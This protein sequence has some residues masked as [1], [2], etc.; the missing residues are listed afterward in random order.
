[1]DIAF[2]AISSVAAAVATS[3]TYAHTTTGSDPILF[4]MGRDKVAAA[5]V[6]TGITYNSVSL[7]NVNGVQIPSSR[8]MWIY[9]MVAPATGAHNVVV[10]ASESVSLRSY[11]ATYSGAKQSSQPDGNNTTTG[12]NPNLTISNTITTTA[13]NCWMIMYLN[14]DQGAITYSTSTGDTIRLNNDGGGMCFM[15]TGGPITPAGSNTMT[16]TGTNGSRGGLAV[17]FS[18]VVA[19]TGNFLSLLIP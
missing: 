8:F 11:A 6:V 4:A 12:T 10:S 3:L 16:L 17:S 2:D 15:D 13:D 19:S 5:S 7:T 9:Y 18:P 14:D 1:M